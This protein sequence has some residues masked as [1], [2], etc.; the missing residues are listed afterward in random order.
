MFPFRSKKNQTTMYWHIENALYWEQGRQILDEAHILIAGASRCGKS[1][2]IHKLMWTALASTPASTQFII[3]DMKEGVEMMRY[4]G[5]PHVL[6][7]ADTERDAIAAL[8]YA[9]GITRARLQEMKSKGIVKY[10]GS[11]LYVVIDELGFLLQACGNEALSRLTLLGRIAAAAKVHLLMATQDPSRRGCPSAIQVNCTCCIG[12]RCKSAMESR[13][14]I[15]MAGCE[16][17][18]RYGTAYITLGPDI[19]SLPINP[20][21]EAAYAERIMYWMNPSACMF[22]VKEKK[23]KGA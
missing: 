5:L 1:T 23:R 13:Q 12:M 22:T 9:V 16:D 14:I 17:L 7:F 20:M 4:A 6:R 3:I 8:D 10:D 2:L 15:G 19:Y 18:P 11:D 21:P